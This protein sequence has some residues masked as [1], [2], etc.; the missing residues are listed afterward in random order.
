MLKGAR[1]PQRGKAARRLTLHGPPH[2]VHLAL[3][4]HIDT[5]DQIEEGALARAVRP[6]QCMDL[7]RPQIQ[8]HIIIGQQAA[9]P[10]GDVGCRQQQLPLLGRRLLREQ[11]GI[12]GGQ[13][14]CGAGNP[15]RGQALQRRPQPIRETL[16]H[17]HHQ[18]AENDHLVVARRAQQRGK[19][20]LQFFLE[21]GDRR[22]AQHR[23]P[24]MARAAHHGHEKVFNAD[25]EIERRRAHKALHMRVQPARNRRQHGSQHKQLGAIARGIHAHG[26][27]HDAPA[28]ECTDRTPDARIQQVVHEPQRH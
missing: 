3:R 11:V 21:Q 10:P 9:K 20:V 23:P 22:C 24:Q 15:P 6:D 17:Q 13:L 19:N 4:W 5:R 12:R 28:L 2:Q 8:R 16:Q 27:G 1:K 14:W 25:V 7:A 26:F 18:Q